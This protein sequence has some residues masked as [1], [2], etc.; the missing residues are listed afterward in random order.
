MQTTLADSFLHQLIESF[1][2]KVKLPPFLTSIML[3]QPIFDALLLF[4]KSRKEKTKK[5]YSLTSLQMA[6]ITME[7]LS[8]PSQITSR[9]TESHLFADP[10]KEAL[11]SN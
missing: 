8:S 1:T 5:Q 10:M 3:F 6:M 2:H 9:F 11:W 7:T 4:G